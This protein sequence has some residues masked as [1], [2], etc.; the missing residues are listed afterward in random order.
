MIVTKAN[1]IT[2]LAAIFITATGAASRV[3]PCAAQ[4]SVSPNNTRVEQAAQLVAEGATALERNDLTAARS[5]FQHALELNPKDVAAHTYLGIL[6]DRA[7]DLTEAERNFAAAVLADPISPSAHNNHGAILL[8]LGRT[9]EAAAEFE[10]S[11]RLDRD[12]PSASV[13]L[14]QIRS[15]GSAPADLRE[16]RELFERAFAIAPDVEIAR[17]LTVISLQ[18]KDREAA[19]NYFREYSARLV[20]SS[21]QATTAAARAELGEALL[22]AGLLKEAVMELN[23]AVTAD[24]ANADTVVRMAKAYLALNDIPS[25]GRTLEAAVARGLDTAPIYALLASIYEKSGHIEN[26]IPAMRLAIQRD[27]QS[28][29]YRFVYGMLLTSVLA[30][31]AA[32]IRLKEALEMFPRS[33]RLW[34]A[35]GIAHF[36]AGRNDEA[37]QALTRAIE[38]DPKFAPAYA[39]LGMTYVDIGQY[40]EA[41]KAYE[42]ALAV[43]EKLGVVDFLI[44]DAVQ[45]HATAET[46]RIEAHLVRAVKLEPSF[47]PASLALGKLYFRTNRLAEAASELERVI[48]LDPNLAEAYYQLSRVYA[49]LKRT[50]EAQAILA[51]FKRLSDSQ[52]EQEQKQRAEIV[53]RLA[54]VLF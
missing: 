11:L 5:Q 17:A 7:G 26:A 50:E 36:K 41:I 19:T 23:V 27:P 45:K 18:L 40:D 49:R 35:L 38:L 15:A 46:A 14:A 42:Q 48:K 16:A 54:N 10:A 2:T 44:A 53:R 39:Y 22:E 29:M 34:L 33:A 31:K 43:N 37:A 8:K 52:K 20:G 47:A 30:P 13:N 1:S 51:A 21:S 24:P 4:S 32:V 6:A 9:N 25:A 3:E 28:E 12:Q